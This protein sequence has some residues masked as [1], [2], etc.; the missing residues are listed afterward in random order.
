[1]LQ[2]AGGLKTIKTKC[3]R[4]MRWSSLVEIG[5]EHRLLWNA[6][7]FWQ[8]IMNV[9]HTPWTWPSIPVPVLY[10]VVSHKSPYETAVFCS[11]IQHF[12]TAS[13]RSISY[14]L[15]HSNIARLLH[16]KLTAHKCSYTCWLTHA[17]WKWFLHQ[18]ACV[19]ACS[20]GALDSIIKLKK[21][22]RGREMWE[23]WGWV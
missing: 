12:T 22:D 23:S 2:R 10:A 1:M 16:A 5:V 4:A 17:Q 3:D 6:V 8:G 21:R 11:H 19:A 20:G 14:S 18:P 7:K 9:K 13:L 15:A